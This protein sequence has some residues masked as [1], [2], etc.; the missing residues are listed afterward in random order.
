VGPAP[1]GYGPE[2]EA[3]VEVLADQLRGRLVESGKDAGAGLR[4]RLAEARSGRVERARCLAGRLLAAANSVDRSRRSGPPGPETAGVA[5]PAASPADPGLLSWLR[6]RT[7]PGLYTPAVEQPLAARLGSDPFGLRM[8]P[9]PPTFLAGVP[10]SRLPAEHVAPLLR[11]ISMTRRRPPSAQELSPDALDRDRGRASVVPRRRGWRRWG[12]PPG[13]GAPLLPRKARVPHV[14]HGIWLG[15]P[16]PATSV[17]WRNYAATG[18]RAPHVDDSD[19]VVTVLAAC[20]T[21][22][23]WQLVARDGNLYLS[24]VGPVIRGLPDPDAAWTALLSTLPV[25]AAGLPP[26]TSITDL[27]RNDNGRLEP[28]VLPPEAEALLDR[29]AAP[30]RWLGAALSPD[31]LPVWL[32]DERVA[33]ATLRTPTQPAPRYLDAVGRLAEV[34]LNA[35]GH[36]IGLWL[37][38][39]WDADRW[40]EHPRFTA[41]PP[42][43]VGV[44]VGTTGPDTAHELNLHP[45][46]VAILLLQCGMAG[47]PVQL[48]APPDVNDFTRPFATRLQR[49]LAQPVHLVE[50]TADRGTIRPPRRPLPP[51]H[52]VPFSTFQSIRR[53]PERTAATASA[54]PRD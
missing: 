26:V 34:A 52:Y 40:R 14:V 20:L 8:L 12:Q 43:R 13:S 31:G 50:N 23:L 28:V 33:P 36:P 4:R 30:R 38:S 11:R 25:L 37:R 39:P 44:E 41:L 18:D 17:F 16:L 42:S 22:L 35:F 51:M 15:R 7:H 10:V 6:A 54:A 29:S 9:E 49:L 3:A 19:R 21:F 24:A 45:E 53:A 2:L 46:A 27:R 47:R 48:T 32:L 1:P 5:V